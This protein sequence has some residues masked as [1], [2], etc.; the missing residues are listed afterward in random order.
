MKVKDKQVL[1]LTS[2]LILFISSSIA[3]SKYEFYLEPFKKEFPFLSNYRW[4]VIIEY[5]YK[6]HI[7]LVAETQIG[8]TLLYIN[9]AR[10]LED[11]IIKYKLRNIRKT[12]DRNEWYDLQAFDSNL[13]LLYWCRVKNGNIDEKKFIVGEY[14]FKFDEDLMD[15]G[16]SRFYALHRDSLKQVKGNN[17]P[18]LPRRK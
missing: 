6:E 2:L 8:D 1:L 4:E 11:G 9:A 3:Q 18:D 15:E 17:L 16:Q 7:E 12:F 10:V 13:K 5:E 14:A